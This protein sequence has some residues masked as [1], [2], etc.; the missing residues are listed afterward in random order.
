[1]FGV[2]TVTVIRGVVQKRTSVESLPIFGY[3]FGK[4]D[5]ANKGKEYRHNCETHIHELPGFRCDRIEQ[6][7][8]H[9]GNDIYQ[10]SLRGSLNA[11]N[12]AFA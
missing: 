6:L 4:A 5:R 7:S 10:D 3:P 1:M 2:K 12:L 11:R 8:V 9:A